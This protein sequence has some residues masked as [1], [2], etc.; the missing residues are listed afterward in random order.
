ML[1]RQLPMKR[2]ENSFVRAF[3]LIELLIV[4]ACLGILAALLLPALA[5]SNVRSAR[6]NCVN[7]LKQ[8]GVAFRVWALDNGDRYPPQ[9]P[10]MSGG[11]RELVGSG[12]VYPHF[13]AMSNELSTPK[14]L[15][16]PWDTR[17]Q[18]L[19]ATTFAPVIPTGSMNTVPFTNDLQVS[20][21]VGVDAESWQPSMF[22]SGDANLG[23]EGNS[24]KSGLQSFSTNSPVAWFQ[25]RHE[26][27]KKGNMGLADGSVQV[28]DTRE[29]RKALRE[30]GATNRLA[31]PEF[32]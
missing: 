14:I 10:L 9:T 22:L 7:N 29:L 6:I 19:I 25:P 26:K 2:C 28:F 23:L 4:I 8:I 12:S 21:F 5:R 1:D 30:S 15:V 3:T 20:Y 32:P 11:T 18:S 13:Q 24:L 17:R 31:I 27:G 16:C